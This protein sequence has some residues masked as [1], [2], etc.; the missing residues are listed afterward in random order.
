MQTG[1]GGL[2][3]YDRFA[4]PLYGDT[5]LNDSPFPQ[6]GQTEDFRGIGRQPDAQATSAPAAAPEAGIESLLSQAEGAPAP[7]P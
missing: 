1:E 3:G 5:G 2:P 6:P 4:S 7:K